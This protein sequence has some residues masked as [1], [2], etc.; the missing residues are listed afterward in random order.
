MGIAYAAAPSAAV[1]LENFMAGTAGDGGSA[2]PGGSEQ[3][4]GVPGASGVC[5]DLSIKATSDK[6]GVVVWKY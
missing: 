5:W 4:A 2:G 3:N 6:R 1:A